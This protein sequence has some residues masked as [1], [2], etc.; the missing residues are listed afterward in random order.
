MSAA[1][2]MEASFSDR[3]QNTTNPIQ[4]L[5]SM[6]TFL[7]DGTTGCYLKEKDL[8]TN[9]IEAA[10]DFKSTERLIR[11]VR[12]AGI[13]SLELEIVLAFDG[14]RSNITLAIDERF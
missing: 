1:P 4:T 7:R 6:K 5:P 9:S 14:E 3:P 2:K 10:L 11:F 13:S 8:W 12:D